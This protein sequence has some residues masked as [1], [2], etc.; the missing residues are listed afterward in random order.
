MT[1]FRTYPA[2]R[3]I[4]SATYCAMTLQLILILFSNLRLDLPTDLLP[5][6]TSTCTKLRGYFLLLTKRQMSIL[7]LLFNLIILTII[8]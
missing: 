8:N 6:K 1:L 5:S 2:H 3:G 7:S 4:Q